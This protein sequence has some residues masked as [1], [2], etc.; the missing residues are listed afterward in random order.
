MPGH[1]VRPRNFGPGIASARNASVEDAAQMKPL[2]LETIATA[3]AIVFTPI[4][5]IRAREDRFVNWSPLRP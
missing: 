2:L 1:R 4:A 3:T 5:L